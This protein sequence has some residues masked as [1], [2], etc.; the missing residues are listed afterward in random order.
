MI[1]DE[2]KQNE[3][4]IGN[5]L[6]NLSFKNILEKYYEDLYQIGRIALWKA[7]ETKDD[8]KG[9]FYS[10]A[11]TVIKNAILDEYK[12]KIRYKNRIEF[13]KTAEFDNEES[14]YFINYNRSCREEFLV[15][16]F[17]SFEKNLTAEE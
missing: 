4:I 2:I 13:E 3:Y 15:I 12:S 16:D 8:T 9:N 10:Y 11:Y 14:N 7:I 6:K 5:V 17:K 1:E